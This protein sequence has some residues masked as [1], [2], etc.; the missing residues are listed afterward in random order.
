MVTNPSESSLL[1]SKLQKK[2]EKNRTPSEPHPELKECTFKPMLTARL[3][4]AKL[5]KR[6]P[7]Q[8]ASTGCLRLDRRLIDSKNEDISS[9]VTYES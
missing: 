3:A 8:T 6:K 5:K 4:Q 1:S 2:A 7:G 9:V